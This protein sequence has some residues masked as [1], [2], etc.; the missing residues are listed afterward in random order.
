MDFAAVMLYGRRAKGLAELWIAYG[1][2]IIWSGILSVMIIYLINLLSRKNL[3]L[4]TTFISLGAWFTFYAVPKLF[5][6]PELMAIHWQ[7]AVSHATTSAIDGLLL[8][9][10]FLWFKRSQKEEV[11]HMLHWTFQDRS[12]KGVIAG[13]ISGLILVGLNFL[14]FYPLHFAKARYLDYSGVLLYGHS[15]KMLVESYYSGGLIYQLPNRKT[16]ENVSFLR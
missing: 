2:E 9:L 13:L 11:S 3:L 12:T 10:I 7:S 15:P 16:K 1:S 8:G 14:S 4:K 6:V 5:R